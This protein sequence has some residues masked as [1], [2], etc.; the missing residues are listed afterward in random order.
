MSSLRLLIGRIWHRPGA[1]IILPL[2]LSM[3]LLRPD[4]FLATLL[5]LYAIEVNQSV[6]ALSSH[7]PAGWPLVVTPGMC[8]DSPVPFHVPP[9]ITAS[10]RSR[11]TRFYGMVCLASGDLVSSRQYLEPL[12]PALSND[13]SFVDVLGAVWV[14]SGREEEGI[15]LWKAHGSRAWFILL[16]Q[17]DLDYGAGQFSQATKWLDLAAPFLAEPP[18]ADQR[19]FYDRACVIY[20]DDP[21]RFAQAIASCQALVYLSPNSG[22]AKMLLGRAYLKAQEYDRARESLKAAVALE[23]FNGVFYYYLGQSYEGLQQRAQALQVYE[24]SVQL[25]PEYGYVRLRLAELELS[26]GND[27]QAVAHLLVAIQSGDVYVRQK[28]QQELVALTTKSSQ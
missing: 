18:T 16:R 9:F 12:L 15:K 4:L 2:I 8:E 28:A 6:V 5:N 1:G 25:A 3:G 14:A 11:L 19:L 17:A 20:R 24:R 23:P 13:R 21:K 26:R 10:V 7:Q 27:D 22:G